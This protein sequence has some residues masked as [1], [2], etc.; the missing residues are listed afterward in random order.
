VA[1]G[2]NPALHPQ[3]ASRVWRALA[4]SPCARKLAQG[5]IRWLELLEAIGARDAQRMVAL[6]VAVLDAAP[7]AAGPE[8]EI[9]ILA[10]VTGALCLGNANAARV[11][12]ENGK[13][14][15]IRPD[16]HA[17]SVRFL[18]AQLR[19]PPAAGMRCPS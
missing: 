6:A 1:G 3:A 4:A 15:W 7:R 18:E 10:G 12:L 16:V 9:A 14:R 8:S 13:A 17:A 11:L 5:E 2:V 19:S